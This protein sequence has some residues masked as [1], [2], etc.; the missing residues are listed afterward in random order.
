VVNKP[1]KKLAGQTVVYGL[2]TIVPRLLNFALTPIL[3]DA[4]STAEFGI[5]S[6]LYAYISFLNVI[7]TYGMETTFFNFSSKLDRHNSVY[8]TAFTSLLISTTLFT[9]TLICF[10]GTIARALST[11]NANY[12]PKFITWCVLII[13]TDAL[14]VIPFAKLRAEG[15][16]VKFSLL[17]LGNIVV[18]FGLTLFFLVLCKSH[19]EKGAN[20]FYA[21][22]YNP[23]IGIGYVFLATL[24][25]NIV[26]L[27]FLSPQFF[28]LT[29][30]PDVELLKKML[31]Y[32]WPLIILGLAGMVNETLDRIIL[33]KLIADKAQAQNAL[34]IY[35]ACYKISILMT[36]FRQAF[37]FAADPF[38]FG[39]AKDP[40]SKQLYA[41]V[42]KYF[43]IFCLFLFLATMFNLEWIKYI[44]D[45][46]YWSGLKVVPILLLANLCLGVMYNLSIW[47]K[48]GNLTKFGIVIAITGAVITIVLNVLFVPVYSYMACAWATLAAYAGMMILSYLL[49][50]KYYPIKY[51]LRAIGVY[52][53]ITTL[54]YL[55]SLTYAGTENIILKLGLNNLL[56][57]IFG[58]IVY[59]LE[60]NNLKKIK[61]NAIA[62]S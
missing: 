41:V 52:A 55:I 6:E 36:I 53:V 35:G 58:I 9:F 18:N 5:N 17:K 15:K 27:L 11:P 7:F 29:F 28:S 42:M 23:Q 26:T 12:L 47:F 50:Q 2:G 16:A 25:A 24:I 4:F 45:E 38:F 19:H 8:N 30:K 3:T 21:F 22:I 56:I 39:K 13:A 54:L 33:K 46:D 14:S 59:K 49:G 60:I 61:T 10:S 34:G 1:I 20:D 37:Q 32:A 31:H 57:V 43:I 51:N 62:Q 44:V 48:L 40:D